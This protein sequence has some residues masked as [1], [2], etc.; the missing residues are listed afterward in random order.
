MTP[1]LFLKINF[2]T[3]VLSFQEMEKELGSDGG[4][5][6]YNILKTNGLNLLEYCHSY[7]IS[8]LHLL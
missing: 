7:P 6:S 1:A 5:G 4:K 8:I 2:S 3:N